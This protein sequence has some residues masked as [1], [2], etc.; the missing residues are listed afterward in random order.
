M[1]EKWG[2]NGYKK[3]NIKLYS[4]YLPPFCGL[5]PSA[6]MESLSFAKR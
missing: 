1:R 5:P 2:K 4:I 3:Y 6:G